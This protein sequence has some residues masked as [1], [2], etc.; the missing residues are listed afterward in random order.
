MEN[1]LYAGDTTSPPCN[2]SAT[3]PIATGCLKTTVSFESSDFPVVDD[4]T[5]PS[6][7][8]LTSP[9][10]HSSPCEIKLC[11][12]QK[13]EIRQI[14]VRSTARVYEIYYSPTWQAPDEYLCTVR[15]STAERDGEVLQTTTS[16]IVED[17][18]TTSVGESTNSRSPSETNGSSENDW[19]E[20][21]SPISSYDSTACCLSNKDDFSLGNNTQDLYEATAEIND[22]DPC[23]SIT[24]RLLS[25]QNKCRVVVDEVYVFADPVDPSDSENHAVQ[26]GS[27]TG[28]AL[29]AMLVPTLMQ[30]SKS[31]SEKTTS[32]KLTTDA[33][34][35]SNLV[36]QTEAAEGS[37]QDKKL[38][39]EQQYVMYDTRAEPIPP[40]LPSHY[41]AVDKHAPSV[42]NAMP[43]SRIEGLLEQLVSRVSRVEDYFS[44]FEENILKP[45]NSIDT[46]LSMVEQ[47]LEILTNNSDTFGQRGTRFSA[48]SF[49]CGESNSSLIFYDTSRDTPQVTELK[50]GD[51]HSTY[52]CTR[53]NGSPA[54]ESC[55][56]ILPAFRITVSEFTCSEGDEDCNIDTLENANVLISSGDTSLEKPKQ[57]VSVDDA[58]AK[59]LSGFLTMASRS[60]SEDAGTQD[61]VANS[62]DSVETLPPTSFN[63]IAPGINSKDPSEYSQVSIIPAPEFTTEIQGDE[64]FIDFKQS[65]SVSVF[66]SLKKEDGAENVLSSEMDE[67]RTPRVPLDACMFTGGETIP[68]D[69]SGRSC[70]KQSMM[71]NSVVDDEQVHL[72]QKETNHLSWVDPDACVS[73]I[74]KVLTEA[75]AGHVSKLSGLA[76][77]N[78]DMLSVQRGTTNKSNTPEN[79]GGSVGCIGSEVAGIHV[80]LNLTELPVAPVVDLE[81]PILEVKFDSHGSSTTGDDFY[82]FLYDLPKKTHLRWSSVCSLDEVRVAQEAEFTCEDSG[83]ADDLASDHNLLVDLSFDDVDELPNSDSGLYDP[84]TSINHDTSPSLI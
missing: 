48:P 6:P 23:T 49:S 45:I 26:M 61:S 64:E 44:R 13:Y 63:H 50:E 56:H 58:L 9:S 24:I 53:S 35:V 4:S 65:H 80:P 25:L 77:L 33:K 83:R 66:Q 74:S 78:N 11:F 39:A 43:H 57:T 82:G 41:P 84:S 60:K 75:D 8:L 38:S 36:A 59:A 46:R 19:V 2:S 79:V 70:D 21:K 73:G 51:T 28:N 55:R 10:D 20:V 52:S 69:V 67:L 29:M 12:K 40:Q 34:V 42:E 3:W 54:P 30:F 14:Y 27:S 5:S 68:T 18:A 76:E 7:L 15:C 22:A 37:E 1:N 32:D 81:F 72:H 47:K 17:E 71:S 62:E 16:G 31:S